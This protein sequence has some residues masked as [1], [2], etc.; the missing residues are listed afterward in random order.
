MTEMTAHKKGALVEYDKPQ[1]E[2]YGSIE[3]LTAALCN[4]GNEDGSNKQFH[5]TSPCD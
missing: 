1:I 5:A 3:E 4:P 2:D